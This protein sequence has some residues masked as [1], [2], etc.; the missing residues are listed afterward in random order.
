M[1]RTNL[2]RPLRPGETPPPGAA[3]VRVPVETWTEPKHPKAGYR[4]LNRRCTAAVVLVEADDTRGAEP[5][6][7]TDAQC[8]FCKEL[9][10]MVGYFEVAHLAPADG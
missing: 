5:R 8:P 1:L 7:M 10:R 3:R 2:Y 4:C 9:L 6:L